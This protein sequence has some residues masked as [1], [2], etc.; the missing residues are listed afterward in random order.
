M[1][2]V[3]PKT[4][5]LITGV[6]GC[7]S[8][9]KTSFPPGDLAISLWLSD[10]SIACG[11]G[12]V[13]RDLFAASGEVGA[14]TTAFPI[15]RLGV[16]TEEPGVPLLLRTLLVTGPNPAPEP[17]DMAEKGQTKILRWSCPLG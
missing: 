3:E 11:A 9:A 4:C 12:D 5:K 10:T 7:A 1:S 6:A 2:H 17:C 13:G 15:S 16:D 8:S 14:P